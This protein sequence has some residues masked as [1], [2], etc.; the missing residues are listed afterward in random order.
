MCSIDVYIGFYQLI[1]AKILLLTLDC[2][3]KFDP[4]AAV[5]VDYAKPMVLQSSTRLF[6]MREIKGISRQQRN[7]VSEKEVLSSAY[8][9][10]YIGTSLE[11]SFKEKEGAGEQASR[12][13]RNIEL[14]KHSTFN[15]CGTRP[16]REKEREKHNSTFK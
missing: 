15:A 1:A 2:P 16:D 4:V 10:G 6:Y 5:R 8:H 9:V 11:K 7:F 3:T 13:L 14:L 12:N